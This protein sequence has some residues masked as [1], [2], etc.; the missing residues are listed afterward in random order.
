MSR[1]TI[2]I[3]AMVVVLGMVIAVGRL[4]VGIPLVPPSGREIVKRLSGLPIPVFV[5]SEEAVDKCSGMFCKDY[6]GRG[7][8]LFSPA[9]CSKAVAAAKGQGWRSLALL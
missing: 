4:F 7:L 3:I 8:I 1:K 2:S 6:Y 5:S 9:S